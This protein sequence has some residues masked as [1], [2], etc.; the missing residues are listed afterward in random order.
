MKV[1]V[2]GAAGRMG[3]HLTRRLVAAGHEVRAFVLPGD[4]NNQAID[5]SGVEVV[6]GRLEDVDS[7]EQAVAGVDAIAALAGALTS[8]LASDRQFFDVNLGGTFNLLMAARAHTPNLQRFVY[9]S[10][11]AVYWSGH[12][13]PSRF[14]PRRFGQSRRQTRSREPCTTPQAPS[15]R[16]SS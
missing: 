8:R 5:G 11:D 15:C 3:A 2:T 6:P 10:S 1:L 4:P 13:R 9:A 7:V 12:E 14:L 16:V